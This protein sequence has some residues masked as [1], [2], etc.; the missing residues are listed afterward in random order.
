MIISAALAD[1]LL[2]IGGLIGLITKIYALKD[3]KTTWSRRSSGFNALTYPV[4]ALLPF[5]VLGLWSTLAVSFLNF[6]VWIGIYL[7]RAPES[8]DWF[9]RR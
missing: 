7:F 6:L 8:E 2:A 9:G 4:T 1:T 5:F 3:E